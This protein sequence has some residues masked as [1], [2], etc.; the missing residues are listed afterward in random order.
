MH[1]QD[2]LDNSNL[3]IINTPS[4]LL[5]LCTRLSTLKE[6][7]FDTEYDSFKR[8]YGFKLLL[9]QIFD[10]ENVHIVDPFPLPDLK[11]LWEVMENSSICKILYSGSEDV[12]LLKRL[13]CEV[14][15]IFDVQIAAILCNSEA[16]NLGSLIEANMGIAV[17]KSQQTSDWRS[18]PLKAKQV[19]YAAND[20]LYLIDL[21]HKFSDQVAQRGLLNVLDVENS[22]LEDIPEREHVPKLKPIHYRTYAQAY[23]DALLA[24]I[25]LRDQI[26]QQINLP[27]VH[28]VDTAF[29][30]EALTLRDE[31]LA[32]K[33]FKSFHPKIRNSETLKAQ[34]LEIIESYDPTDLS[35]RPR[36]RTYHSVNWQPP[37]SDEEKIQIISEK[38]EPVK[39]EMVARYGEL[40]SEFLL[41]GL[42][43]ELTSR[44]GRPKK[45]WPY[46][47][48]LL[49]RMKTNDK[50]L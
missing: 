10:G 7:A 32:S 44:D 20:V 48:E 38:Y 2:I 11:P 19:Q 17:D 39:N 28:V 23:C 35:K 46:Q 34:F 13:G 36:E 15:N 3:K 33:Q 37:Y 50:V 22:A 16:R 9:M 8:E 4:Q 30:E 26:A 45:L 42:K 27:P 6:F 1:P 29:L 12:A 5:Q 24:M 41:R 14:K 21:K 47:E 25:L 43:K 18:R 31:F 40:A 49:E